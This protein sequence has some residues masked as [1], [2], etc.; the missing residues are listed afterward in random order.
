M[1][2]PQM[3]LASL[4]AP[5]TGKASAGSSGDASAA[6]HGTNTSSGYG[7]FGQ[8]NTGTGVYGQSGGGGGTYGVFGLNFHAASGNAVGVLGHDSSNARC[9]GIPCGF[10][11][12]VKAATG[13]I[14]YPGAPWAF[15]LQQQRRPPARWVS[16][17]R[18]AGWFRP[19][20]AR[21]ASRPGTA[22]GLRLA[23]W[24]SP[25]SID[26]GGISFNGSTRSATRP[27][28]TQIILHVHRRDRMG[29]KP[30]AAIS[31]NQIPSPIPS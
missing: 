20:T 12:A 25:L 5:P 3:A 29:R 4:A 17:A 24:L 30:R 26:F 22:P 8:S 6:I 23:Q 19:P 10:R 31:N 16:W 11:P 27:A 1:A 9:S 2:N 18:L 14:V 28:G 7:V 13:G 15:W 21:P